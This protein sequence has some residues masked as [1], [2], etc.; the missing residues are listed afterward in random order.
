MKFNYKSWKED[1]LEFLK[2]LISEKKKKSTKKKEE[3]EV[4]VLSL[5]ELN[6]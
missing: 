3:P 1:Y 2:K 5:E 6:K 4:E